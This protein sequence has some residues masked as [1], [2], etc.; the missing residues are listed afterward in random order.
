[1]K[2]QFR[3][4]LA[5]LF[6]ISIFFLV[7][8]N[9]DFKDSKKKPD[10]SNTIFVHENKDYLDYSVSIVSILVSAVGIYYS[11]K[12]FKVSKTTL[13]GSQEILTL[14]K[15]AL[16]ED[17][18]SR[19][20]QFWS[21]IDRMIIEQPDL[22]KFYDNN[23]NLSNDE[24][25]ILAFVYYKLNHY[26]IIYKDADEVTK[27]AWER[28]IEYCLKKSSVFKHVVEKIINDNEELKGLYS[29]GFI[30]NLDVLYM[31]VYTK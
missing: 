23:S 11:I 25:R 4:G 3:F 31:R 19:N 12:M 6:L 7:R 20:L 8:N 28:Y 29:E 22:W 21:E 2:P 27:N 14:S 10:K 9:L 13:E 17:V 30:D 26:E 18:Y 15:M 24:G 16:K 5:F 1:M